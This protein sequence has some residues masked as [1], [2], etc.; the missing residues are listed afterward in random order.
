MMTA[1]DHRVFPA[2]APKRR[3]YHN[4][5]PRNGPLKRAA[6]STWLFEESYSIVGDLA[7]ERSRWCCPPTRTQDDQSLST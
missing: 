5:V 7:R 6:D 2:V 1:M 4:Q 3:R